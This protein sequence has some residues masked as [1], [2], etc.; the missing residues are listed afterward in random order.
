MGKEPEFDENGNVK[1]LI[2]HIDEMVALFQQ[3]RANPDG[4]EFLS[5]IFDDPDAHGDGA[6]RELG[7]LAELL[8]EVL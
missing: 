4:A 8:A 5:P 3:S 7:W 6:R 2:F 1:P